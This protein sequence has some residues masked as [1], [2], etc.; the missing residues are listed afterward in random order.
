MSNSSSAARSFASPRRGA[1]RAASARISRKVRLRLLAVAVDDAPAGQVV[2]AQLDPDAVTWR[3]PDEEAAHPAGGVGHEL[4]T[5]LQL[6][7]EHGV[8]K[9]LRDDRVHHDGG[10]FYR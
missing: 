1:G 8:R 2:R 10:F 3:D 4:V 5:V 7:L 9:R 6:N